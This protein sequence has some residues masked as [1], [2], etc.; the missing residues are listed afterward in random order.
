MLKF[1]STHPL[2]GA[3]PLSAQ[4]MANGKISIHAPLAGCDGRMGLSPL[5]VMQFQST[6]PLRGATATCPNR[7]RAPSR[8]Q[9][10]HPLRGA[11]GAADG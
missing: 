4:E 8:F 7:C 11:T 1:Q 9:S 2:R 5:A 10:T 3:T 6:H